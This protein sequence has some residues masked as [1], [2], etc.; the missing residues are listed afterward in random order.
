MKTPFATKVTQEKTVRIGKPVEIKEPELSVPDSFG[1]LPVDVLENKTEIRVVAPLA[2]V[3]IDEVEILINNDV[4]TIKGKRELDSEVTEL[5]GVDYYA[6]E[7]FWGEF[8]RSIIL[9]PH[10]DTD[11]I[12]ATQKNHILYIRIPKK[13][14]ISMR[15][16]K[17]RKK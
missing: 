1:Q 13:P 17:I 6:Q 10:A 4:L 15:I 3:E 14:A 5:K 11:Q 9:P 2:G 16:V 8:S 7:C 12:E